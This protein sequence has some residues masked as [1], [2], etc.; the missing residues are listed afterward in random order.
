MTTTLASKAPELQAL[1]ALAQD[2]TSCDAPADKSLAALKALDVIEVGDL[3]L[4][5]ASP[6]GSC[7]SLPCPAEV[8]R[9]QV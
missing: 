2:D 1:V 4:A 8:E 7:Y 5:E 3:L 6:D 9:V